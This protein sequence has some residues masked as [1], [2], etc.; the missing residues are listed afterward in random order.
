[1]L[2]VFLFDRSSG[3]CAFADDALLA[4]K[5]NGSGGEKQLFQ[6]DTVWDDKFQ[7]W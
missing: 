7:K 2:L 4:H 3:H 5:M 1:M 6:R